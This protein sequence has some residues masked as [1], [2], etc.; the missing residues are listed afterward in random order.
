MYAFYAGLA[1]GASPRVAGTRRQPLARR[2]GSARAAQRPPGGGALPARPRDDPGRGRR[3]ER[4]RP[5]PVPRHAHRRGAAPL[6]PAGDGAR[7]G[8]ARPGRRAR[9]LRPHPPARPAARRRAA[10]W[11]TLSGTRLWN[12]GSWLYEGAFVTRTGR[13]SPYWPGTVLTLEDEA[14][15]PGSRTS[16]RATTQARRGASARS[17][18]VPQRVRRDVELAQCAGGTATCRWAT[19][20]SCGRSGR[21]SSSCSRR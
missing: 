3:A 18:G 7:G 15:R 17:A 9:D 19:A 16:L 1:Q 14:R 6:R 11:T 20:P 5:R 2:S 4:P 12:T 8:G 10:E 21:C 13:D